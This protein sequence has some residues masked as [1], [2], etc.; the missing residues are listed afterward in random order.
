MTQN[1]NHSKKHT[2]VTREIHALKTQKG[3][4]ILAARLSGFIANRD[5]RPPSAVLM[6]QSPLRILVSGM[7][8]GVPAQGGATWAVLQY[9]IGLR[10]LGHKVCFVEPVPASSVTPKD[11]P[12][13]R[14]CNA[15]Y[16]RSVMREFGFERHSALVATD[17][18]STV[19]LSYDEL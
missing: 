18:L 11:A 17:S 3:C 13:D 10:E 12:L 15:A 19:G 8:A 16:F 2:S 1:C 9:L 14:S 7:I 5:E 4:A 6:H